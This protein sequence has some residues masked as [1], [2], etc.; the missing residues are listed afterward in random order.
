MLYLQ[1]PVQ[2]GV[3]STVPVK[4][5]SRTSP[6]GMGVPG[7]PAPEIVVPEPVIFPELLMVVTPITVTGDAAALGPLPSGTVQPISENAQVPTRLPIL[8]CC[9]AGRAQQI[10]RPKNVAHTMFPTR[11]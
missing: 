4:S 6:A 11:I 7:I 5:K 2:F 10:E 1:E 3:I 9:C 8:H